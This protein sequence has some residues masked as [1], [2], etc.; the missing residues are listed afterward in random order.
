MTLVQSTPVEIYELQL[1][2]FRLTLKDLEDDFEGMPWTKTHNH[3]TEV[4]L[5]GLTFARVIEIL[6]PYT[7]TFEDGQ[8]AVNLVGANSN[9]GDVVNVNQVSVRS[10]NS[11]G[12]ISNPAIEFASF[13]GF[14]TIDVLS[15]FSGTSYPVGTR[16]Q[17]V[18]NLADAKQIASFRGLDAINILGDITITSTQNIDDFTMIG[19][20][21]GKTVIIVDAGASTLNTNFTDCELSGTLYGPKSFDNVHFGTLSID[22]PGGTGES[23]ATRCGFEGNITLTSTVDGNFG[24]IDCFSLIPGTATPSFDF[25]GADVNVSVRRYTGGMT[26]LNYSHVSG[27]VTSID[28]TSGNIIIDSTCTTG[29]IVVRGISKLTDNGNGTTVDTT[30][31]IFADQLQLASFN[32]RVHLDPAAG[33]VGTKFPIGT[34]QTPA[35]TLADAQTIAMMRGITTI[36]L[37]G[38]L[39]LLPTDDIDGFTIEGDNALNA[40]AAVLS[41]C[42]TEATRFTD[43]ILTGTVSGGIYCEKV[44]L[45]N[46]LGIGSDAGPS[47]FLE[48]TL[49]EGTCALRNGLGAPQNVQFADCTQGVST[50]SGTTFDFN[51]GASNVAF[52]KFGG[53]ITIAGDTSGL[54]RALDISQGHVTVAASCT[55]GTLNISGDAGLTDNSTGT[56]TVAYAPGEGDF[57][58]T[59]RNALNKIWSIAKALL[60]LS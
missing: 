26:I 50:G 51:G 31:L 35:K 33:T 7:V 58:D 59:D 16:R 23:T 41:G 25:G 9:V 20:G 37:V 18:N 12:L 57:T 4:T 54:V 17:P 43:L 40:I 5:G 11:A 47:L 21:P 1:D 13:E 53:D 6:A 52:R 15:D 34:E 24:F 38:T 44:G 55:T 29:T 49:L 22:S 8:Y 45:S 36:H 48:C 60:G 3:N 14:V 19:D 30:G 46:V 39:V 10:Q 42:S 56:Y 32:E 2:G 27:P 28:M